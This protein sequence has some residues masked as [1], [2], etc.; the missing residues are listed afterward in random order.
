MAAALAQPVPSESASTYGAQI[1]YGTGGIDPRTGSYFVEYQA[2]AGGNGA[3][4]FSDGVSTAGQ[5]T[6]GAPNGSVEAD[7]IAYPQ[8]IHRYEL[9]QNSGGVGRY[10]GGLGIRRV[11]SV[12]GDGEH[13]LSTI[14]NRTLVPPAGLFGGGPGSAAGFV[15]HRASGSAPPIPT[16]RAS[17]RPRGERPVGLTGVRSALLRTPGHVSQSLLSR[18]AT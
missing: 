17:G 10:R 2:F 14:A 16:S 1:H 3:T 18:W 4:A 5:W 9:R 7:E 11:I 13:P 12:Y 8:V 6:S 15:L